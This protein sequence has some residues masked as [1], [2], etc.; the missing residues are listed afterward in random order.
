MAP[1]L[2]NDERPDVVNALVAVSDPRAVPI[3]ERILTDRA[4]T[5]TVREAAGYV[6]RN[7]EYLDV[8]W[9]EDTLRGWWNSPD[10]V[11]HRHA[12]RSMGAAACPDIVRAVARDPAHPLRATALDRMIFFFDAPADVDMK[13]EA[14]AASAPEVRATAAKILF[15][16]E[17]VAAETALVT[18]AADPV[19]RV[20]VEALLTLQYYPSRHVIRSLHGRLD[21]PTE[22][23]R[24]AARES[25]DEIR[26]GCLRY[27]CD[28]GPRVSARVRRWL[29]PVWDL[30]S[31]TD[32]EL[33]PLASEPFAAQLARETQPPI[34]SDLVRLLADPDTSPKMLEE[35]LWGKAWAM[36]PPNA[37]RQVRP[38]MLNH[39]DPLVR[40][41]SIEPLRAWGDTDGL[42]A[43][44]GDPDFGVRKSAMYELSRLP[45]D[46]HIA[47]LAWDHLHQPQTV[48]THATET[49]ATFVAHA[50]RNEAV[51]RLQSI[52]ADRNRPEKLRVAAVDHLTTLQATDEIR[53]LT[54]LLAEP[55]AVT[56]ALHIAALGAATDLALSVSCSHLDD[57]DNLHLQVALATAYGVPG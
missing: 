41:R 51:Q 8:D 2:S 32:E 7:M 55:P 22:P 13:I 34:P 38:V 33:A 29:A 49:L 36:Y 44:A 42:L 19:E 28:D 50:D 10:A 52:A 20:A 57:V 40:Q 4:R 17:P 56:W 12:L 27:V 43:L 6:L 9:S 25:W 48:G 35:V 21:H 23:I 45:P 1:E 39:T 18:A 14:L 26:L 54:K 3:L 37:R 30:L 31:Y 24:H 47:A 15:W 16:D 53:P 11:L 46:P 5:A